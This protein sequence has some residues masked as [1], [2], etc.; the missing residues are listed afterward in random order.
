[1]PTVAFDVGGV[2]EVVNH[3]MTGV[4]VPAGD[5]D[6]LVNGLEGLA[7][8]ADRRAEFGER[9][10]AWCLSH[11]DLQVVSDQFRQ[12]FEQLV[13]GE[14]LKTNETAALSADNS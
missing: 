2:N 3:D 8:R 11:F 1:M 10:R 6:Q 7:N 9:A 13:S 12:L 4:V 14:P 5:F